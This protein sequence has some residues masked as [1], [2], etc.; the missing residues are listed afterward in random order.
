M[1]DNTAILLFCI[2]AAFIV[3]ISLGVL[4]RA[5]RQTKGACHGK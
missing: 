1:P 4:V 2:Y 3:A 5:S